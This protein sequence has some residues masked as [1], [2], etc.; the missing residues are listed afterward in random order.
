[1]P[2]LPYDAVWRRVVI[3]ERISFS[4][5][6]LVIQ[7]LFD[8]EDCHLHSFSIPSEDIF[9]D[10]EESSGFWNVHYPEATTLVDRFFPDYKWIRY[11]YNFRDVR[12]SSK[13]LTKAMREDIQRCL[14]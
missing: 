11:T 7:C 2:I 4:E 6:H 5:L 8:W 3:P 10:E 9:I 14:K 13:K 1:M 12:L